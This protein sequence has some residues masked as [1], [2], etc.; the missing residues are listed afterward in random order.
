MIRYFLILA[1]ICTATNTFAQDSETGKLDK[2]RRSSIYSVLVKHPEKEFCEDIVTVFKSM[3]IPD[4]YDDHNLPHRVINAIVQQK[5]GKEKLDMQKQAIDDFLQKNAIGRRLVAKWFNRKKD[6]SFDVSLLSERG[7]YDA[8]Y[9]DIQLADNTIRGRRLLADAGEELIP[10]TYVLV[11]DIRYV[12]KSETADL[13][14]GVFG[15]LGMLADQVTGG[16]VFLAIN[17]ATQTA[18]AIS[19]SIAGFKVIVTSYLY[20]LDWTPEIAYTFYDRYYMESRQLD[21]EKKTAFD[22]EKELFTLHYVGRSSAFSGKT[23]LRGVNSD[24]EMIRKVCTRALD[25]AIAQLQKEYEEFR[26]KT[27]LYSVDPLMAKIGIKEDIDENSRFEVLE[28]IQNE[29]G[30]ITYERKGIIRPVKECIW[31]NRYLADCEEE[32]QDRM[33]EATK[34][35]K[36][37]GSG[38]YVGMLIRQID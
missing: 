25:K 11:N 5:Q 3:P 22:R 9:A 8:S 30:S 26:V 16:V 37:S 2:Y 28:V 17:S 23:T 32:N 31:D 21:L 27:P 19:Q 33:L 24:Q 29:D 15:V 35:E 38:F 34:F 12:D 10:N 14:G 18:T 4:K 7:F 1:A 36:V 20:R 13:I 6:G